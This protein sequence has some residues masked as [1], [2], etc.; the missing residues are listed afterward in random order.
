[1]RGREAPLRPRLGRSGRPGQASRLGHPRPALAGPTL[2]PQGRWGQGA[3]RP[4]S[5]LPYQAGTGRRT[6]AL[7]ET[8]GGQPLR[9]TLGGRR[10]RLLQAAVLALRQRGELG[11]GRPPAQGRAPVRPAP[12]GPP[13]QTTGADA[14]LRQEPDLPGRAGGRAGGLAAAGVRAVRRA[15]DQDDQDLPGYLSSCR[16]SV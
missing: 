4:A 5:S 3:P 15:R 10:W 13:A 12:D 8:V 2:P 9:G 6:V 11:G 16:G 1:P 14:D 7:A